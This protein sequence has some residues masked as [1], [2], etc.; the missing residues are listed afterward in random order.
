[1]PTNV[2]TALLNLSH[3]LLTGLIPSN[4]ISLS[5]LE[6]L[7]LS[8]NNLSGEVPSSLGSLQSLTLLDLSYNNLSGSVPRFHQ[9]Q[10][11]DIDIVGNPYL[12]TGTGKNYDAPTGMGKRHNTVT[13]IITIT[14]ALFGLC[15]LGVIV[16]IL[17]KGIY[18]VEDE[19][20]PAGEGV[21]Q[22]INGSFITMNSIDTTAIEY[23]KE[24]RDDWRITR[25]QA[26]NFEVADI[27]QGLTEEN[28]VGSGGSGHVYRVTYTDR[29]SSRTG[30]V[31]VKQI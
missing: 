28:L 16:M 31:A 22:I 14:G 29:Y 20:I 21:A 5:E 13:I 30:V 25:F 19:R 12:V 11:V 4:I 27:P 8:H 2:T 24:E 9:N 1:M 10:D 18:H 17:S 26:L 23:M 15:A 3:N 6:F 7:D